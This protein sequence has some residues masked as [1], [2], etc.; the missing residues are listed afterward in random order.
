MVI[1]TDEILSIVG[2]SV[3]LVVGIT[4]LVFL[5]INYIIDLKKADVKLGSSITG[6]FKEK[7]KEID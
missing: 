1:S 5:L 6:Y 4:L 2:L 3:I 7:D